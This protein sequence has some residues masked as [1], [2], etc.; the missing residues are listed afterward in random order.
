M[1]NPD[2]AAAQEMFG[3]DGEKS[4]SNAFETSV[5]EAV[6][7]MTQGEDGLWVLPAD[8][9]E[10]VAFAAKLE[11][12]RRDT[13]SALSKSQSTLKAAEVERD[14]YRGRLITD[15]PLDLNSEEQEEL[16]GLKETSPDAWRVKCNEYEERAV[17]KRTK[18][19]DDL[20]AGASDEAEI[21]R[22]IQVLQD[23]MDSNPELELNDEVMDKDLPPRITGKLERGEITFEEFLDQAKEF[24]TGEEV[25]PSEEPNLSKAGGGSHASKETVAADIQESY[26]TTVF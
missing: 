22:R 20:K 12:R 25:K 16:D 10:N 21:D 9:P 11:K 3:K 14:E 13:Q 6:G 4:A 8:L 7:N 24:I 18:E 5:N 2:N 19:L 15:V 17:T 1:S 23:F 26:K